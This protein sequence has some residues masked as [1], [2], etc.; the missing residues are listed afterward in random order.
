LYCSLYQLSSAS[1]QSRAPYLSRAQPSNSCRWRTKQE[2]AW[3]RGSANAEETSGKTAKPGKKSQ[4]WKMHH[5]GLPWIRSDSF[6]ARLSETPWS[7]NSCHGTCSAW[8][9]LKW[10]GG[11]LTPSHSF[12]GRAAVPSDA[13]RAART[14]RPR[15]RAS[16]APT[17]CSR[18]PSSQAP[19]PGARGLVRAG[20]PTGPIQAVG[21][22]RPGH[23]PPPPDCHR[24]GQARWSPRS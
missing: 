17:S 20:S 13:G 21:R 6:S 3:V 7:R 11:A 4:T 22:R 24:H 15:R 10:V 9:S 14:T 2:K 12:S 23:P 8:A 16:G 18:S 5:P 19:P 1:S